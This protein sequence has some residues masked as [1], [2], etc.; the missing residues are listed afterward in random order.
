MGK[1]GRNDK[2]TCGSGKKYKNCCLNN[3][4]K[5]HEFDELAYIK[6][7]TA[8]SSILWIQTVATH[9]NN[10]LYLQRFYFLLG[11]VLSIPESDFGQREMSYKDAKN[12]FDSIDASYEKVFYLCEDFEGF[13][14]TKLIP[15]FLNRSK[16]YFFYGNLERPYELLMQF[17]ETYF[18]DP[19]EGD[20]DLHTLQQKLIVS[21]EFQTEVLI[22]LL[23]INETSIKQ[24]SM[25][26]PTEEYYKLV[27][28]NFKLNR[29]NHP[30][31]FHY[32]GEFIKFSPQKIAD[33]SVEMSLFSEL[34]IR[35]GEDFVWLLPHIH[36]NVLINKGNQ[37]LKRKPTLMREA[38]TNYETRLNSLCRN[39]FSNSNE[40]VAIFKKDSEVNFLKDRVSFTT[41][42]DQNKLVLFACVDYSTNYDITTNLNKKIKELVTLRNQLQSEEVIGV[43]NYG[44]AYVTG[45]YTKALE[46]WVIPVYESI[47]LD[48]MASVE[49]NVDMSQ[50]FP[51]SSNDLRPVFDKI[52]KP[53]DFLKFLKE[54]NALRERTSG[55]L[56]GEFMDRFFFY[57]KNGNSHM[58]SG[59]LFDTGLF[60]FHMWS[61]FIFN[62]LVEKYRDPAFEE[63]ELK[64]SGFFNRIQNYKEGIYRMIN[65]A[66]LSASYLVKWEDRFIWL[67][68]P[69]KK[70]LKY[71][72]IHI[73]AELVAPMISEYLKKYENQFQSLFLG[74]S[75]TTYNEYFVT[76][77][78]SSL[79]TSVSEFHIFKQYADLLNEDNPMIIVTQ[80]VMHGR[81]RTLIVYD[82]K[83]FPKLFSQ[84]DNIG[85]RYAIKAL[86]KS[87]LEI[88]ENDQTKIKETSEKFINDN[89]PIGVKGYSVEA[90]SV[91]NPNLDD[92]SEPIELNETE[93]AITERI[94]SKFLIDNNIEP[95]DYKYKQAK[96]IN[97]KIYVFLQNI[98][99]NEI[100]KFDKQFII[101]AYR[102][103]ELSEGDRYKR[104]L[105]LGMKSKGRT[106]YDILE[107]T[108]E[109]ENE[110]SRLNICI[111]HILHTSLKIN[112]IGTDFATAE[113]W[114]KLT[115]LADAI[116]AA[117]NIYDYIE[118]DIREH[119][120]QITDDY[121][122][123]DVIGNEAVDL[124]KLNIVHTEI[125]I[126][127]AK[128]AH[129]NAIKDLEREPI[130]ETTAL[131][132][133]IELDKAFE[134]D[135][136]FNFE[137][138]IFVLYS[139]SVLPL[140]DQMHFP[141]S[142][143]SPSKLALEI[144]KNA[145]RGV[146]EETV[147]LILNFLSLQRGIY[148]SNDLLYPSDMM[149]NKERVNV[150]PFIKLED[151]L[152]LYGN[153]AVRLSINFWSSLSLG[154][155]PFVNK[156]YPNIKRAVENIHR[157]EDLQLEKLLETKVI[158]ILGAENV[159]A[160][161]N[162]FK[163]LSETFKSK[164]D[165]G[166]IDLLCVN[167]DIKTLFVIDAKNINKKI[168]IY[169]MKQSIREFFDDKKSYYSKL[170]KKREFI[171]NNLA[172]I[173]RHFKIDNSE[174]WKVKEAFVSEEIYFAAF[175]NKTKVDFVLIEELPAYL[176]TSA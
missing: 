51:I 83:L 63:I 108:K 31:K 118:Y 167:R 87:I 122:I 96:E 102:Q 126:E 26:V 29:Y 132:E 5:Q 34:N 159:E 64:H 165:C 3:N 32:L 123:K 158:E 37:L 128:K 162:N 43:L 130:Q 45:I 9:P 68:L 147:A 89:M 18:F 101:Y 116:M 97:Y 55:A 20:R 12:L 1:L 13:D 19:A 69:P 44:D 82:Y 138:L 124:E 67:Y 93:I 153:E 117:A 131:K 27:S 54:D 56:L 77:L 121:L 115:A 74:A 169:H 71:E 50:I 143:N 30:S 57:I 17:K 164:E 80:H 137:D 99:E 38:Q 125:K 49:K 2:C 42:V 127:K 94:I 66:E 36:L 95:G 154:D 90:H 59:R 86:T 88:Y 156:D 171:E 110:T 62:E 109:S 103:L 60:E 46:I 134:T 72:E 160:R 40:V 176:K 41:I 142:L 152:F 148:K 6:Q 111:K 39:F 149:R 52:E 173:L 150:S 107:A 23:G 170:L 22:K 48:I 136:K 174:D 11:L 161:I 65:T 145:I 24:D 28:N 139:L 163:R 140:S 92:Y 84:A 91:P 113:K 144:N 106:D 73:G 146:S 14:Q 129:T 100:S 104:K 119:T 155:C 4:N 61:D 47:C 166:E 15:F 33:K 114:T 141:V 16:Y 168:S 81:V 120:L 157:D 75:I 133:F 112:T 135:L 70:K 76:I 105:I 25:Y 85:E 53:L 58:R 151:D 79:V 78:P 8:I 10:A 7:F 21:L 35:I 98:L 175:Y 172:A